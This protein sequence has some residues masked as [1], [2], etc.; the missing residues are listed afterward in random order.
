MIKSRILISM[1][2]VLTGIAT[3]FNIP[4][5]EFYTNILRYLAAFELDLFNAAPIGCIVN[6][7]FHEIFL[8]RTIIPLVF[9]V[10]LKLVPVIGPRMKTRMKKKSGSAADSKEAF[11]GFETAAFFIMFLCLTANFLWR[12]SLVL[13]AACL[14]IS[15]W[16]WEV[17]SRLEATA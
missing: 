5:P 12:I 15:L 6:I 2:Q 7:T 8:A 9:I 10:F 1:F 11:D 17:A 4:Y 13:S 16:I 3:T 14:S